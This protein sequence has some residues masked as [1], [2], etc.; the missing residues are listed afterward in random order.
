MYL[1]RRDLESKK[2]VEIN[3]PHKKDMMCLNE[4]TLNPWQAIGD[5]VA[6]RLQTVPLNRYFNPVTGELK[7]ALA[8]YIGYGIQPAQIQFGNGADEMLYYI[9]TAVRESEA[10]FAVSLAPSYFDYKSYCDAVGLQ[11]KMLNFQSDF[12]FDTETY[13]EMTRDPNCKVA[14]LCNPNNPTGNLLPTSQI[15]EIISRCDKLVL[16]DETYFEF[17]GVTLAAK[18]SQYP[19]LVIVRSFSKAFSGAGLRFGYLFTSE[20]NAVELGKV[21][22]A[23]HSSLMIQTF[24]LTMLENKEIFLQ[25]T[26]NVCILRDHLFQEMLKLPGLTVHPSDTNFLTFSVGNETHRLYEV[27]SD[28]DIAVRPVWAHPLLHNHL[29]VSIGSVEQNAAFLN[30]I[31]NFLHKGE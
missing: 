25:H 14:I 17:S 12:T 6:Q 16:L 7:T 13:L 28:N 23:F 10:S 3:V 8:A 20:A 24:A 5:K 21:M 31:R 26:H 11:I 15:E 4:S 1:F 18:L 9:F 2:A 19:N 22:T 29:R 30:V 27:L